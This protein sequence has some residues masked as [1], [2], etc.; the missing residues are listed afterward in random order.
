MDMTSGRELALQTH[1]V[2]ES[3]VLAQHAQMDVQGS[4]SQQQRLRSP[5]LLIGGNSTLKQ[6]VETFKKTGCDIIVGTPGRME[7]FLLGSS[8][9]AL[10]SKKGKA[11]ASAAAPNFRS[12][13]NVKE[14]EMLVLDEADRVLELGY[15]ESINRLLGILPKQRRTG[16][17]SATMS[18][19]LGELCRVGL[20]NPVKV[21]VK[22]E[23]KPNQDGSATQSISERNTPASLSN[24]YVLCEAPAKMARLVQLLAYEAPQTSDPKKIIVYFATCACVD[25]FQRVSSSPQPRAA[26]QC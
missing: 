17:F 13:C 19:G 21:V 11:P 18:E 25:Y 22:V 24:M 15:R 14:L 26:I 23:R 5:L 9:L 8:S 16:C 4:T 12:A 10:K 2:I 3:F 20:R 6:D 1:K 7:E